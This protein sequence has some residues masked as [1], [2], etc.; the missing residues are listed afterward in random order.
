MRLGALAREER[1]MAGIRRKHLSMVLAAVGVVALI[2]VA[3]PMVVS[4]ASKAP[5]PAVAASAG[6]PAIA[7]PALGVG[8]QT[9]TIVNMVYDVDNAGLGGPADMAGPL[10]GT[11]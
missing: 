5:D 11:I 1:D 3:A 7:A 4:G 9:R 6:S 2:A 8:P 10:E